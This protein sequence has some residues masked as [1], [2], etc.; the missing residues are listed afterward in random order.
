M[1]IFTKE[2]SLISLTP[3][4]EA[5]IQD[6]A[7]TVIMAGDPLR[8]K[9]IAENFIE[10]AKLVSSVRGIYCYTGKYKGKRISVMA[11]G[12]GIPSMGIYSYELFHFYDV[13]NIIRVGTCGAFA[14]NLN[15][16]DL[17][18]VDKSYTESNYAYTFDN[19]KCYIMNA[20]EGINNEILNIAKQENVKLEKGTILCNECFDPYLPD[21]TKVLERAPKELD[22]IGSE[23][24]SFA[25]FYNAKREGK[26]A[27]CILTVVDIPNEAK[28]VSAN[29]RQTSLNNMIKLALETAIK[30]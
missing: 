29:E 10:N 15:L 9:Y 7:K 21:K 3:H 11:H 14:E 25:L 12:M 6:I 19:E 30:L 22:I 17:I 23:M 18:L 27:A 5:N 2:R 4:N 1:N 28:S 26:K 24:E 13:D 16:L 8:V 20:D